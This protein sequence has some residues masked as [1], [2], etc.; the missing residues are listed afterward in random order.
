MGEALIV[1]AKKRCTL[2]LYNSFSPLLLPLR[3]VPIVARAAFVG[4]TCLCLS[5]RQGLT[6]AMEV[7]AGLC[8]CEVWQAFALLARSVCVVPLS[9]LGSTVA[10]G[11]CPTKCR[12]SRRQYPR[13]GT[14]FPELTRRAGDTPFHLRTLSNGAAESIIALSRNFLT[15]SKLEYKYGRTLAALLPQKHRSSRLL[16]QINQPTIQI[17]APFCSSNHV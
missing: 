15:L 7:T 8:R 14:R 16:P 17:S 1:R 4:V 9:F 10:V 13:W 5:L 11:Y 2:R 6:L 3:P 12:R